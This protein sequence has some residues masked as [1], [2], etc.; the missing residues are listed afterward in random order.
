ML[1]AVVNLPLY[2]YRSKKLRKVDIGISIQKNYF[3]VLK[4]EILL[5]NFCKLKTDNVTEK[6]DTL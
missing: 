2:C 4:V 1:I 6:A 5:C 3:F